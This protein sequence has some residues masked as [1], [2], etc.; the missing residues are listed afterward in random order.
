MTQDSAD[1]VAFRLWPPVA[2]G[3]PLLVGWSATQVWGD[4][5]ELGGWRIPVGW[6]LVLLFGKSP[7][8]WWGLRDHGGAPYT[9]G[10]S[11]RSSV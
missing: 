2:I 1:T 5:V 4:P 9:E 7:L 11:A 8:E 10:P 6:V 3:A